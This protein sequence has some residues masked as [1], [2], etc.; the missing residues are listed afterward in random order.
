MLVF[1]LFLSCLRPLGSVLGASLTASIDS[2]SIQ[3]T[4]DYVV[5]DTRQVLDTSA[6]DHYHGV[7]L[8]VVTYTRDVSCYLVT[9]C[10]T[11]TGNLTES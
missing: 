11:D 6:A 9:V 8:Q 2:L 7:F 1:S 4:T 3:S 5:T 10:E